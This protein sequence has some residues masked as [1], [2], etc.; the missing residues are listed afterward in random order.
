MGKGGE[1]TIKKK[2]IFG[3]KE[4]KIKMSSQKKKRE[5]RGK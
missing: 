3:E 2:K 4:I 5:G 1:E